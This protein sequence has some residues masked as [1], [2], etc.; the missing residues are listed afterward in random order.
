MTSQAI[1][2]NDSR[3]S[4]FRPH[5]PPALLHCQHSPWLLLKHAALFH[6]DSHRCSARTRLPQH[7]A[8]AAHIWTRNTLRCRPLLHQA[9]YVALTLSVR[10]FSSRWR[11]TS[12]QMSTKHCTT[13]SPLLPYMMRCVS[14]WQPRWVLS[15]SVMLLPQSKINE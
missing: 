10:A 8:T 4:M 14:G 2:R 5:S 3:C 1:R 6:Q 13:N 15:L 11:A 12:W 9:P 7:M